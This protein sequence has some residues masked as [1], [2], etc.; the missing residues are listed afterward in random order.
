ML[1]ARNPAGLKITPA[2]LTEDLRAALD[3]PHPPI[4]VGAVHVLGNWLSGPDPAKALRADE[5]LRRIVANE[6]FV[7]ATAARAHLNPREVQESAGRQADDPAQREVHESA[8]RQADDPAQ[9]EALRYVPEHS[10]ETTPL[11]A[12]GASSVAARLLAAG[13]VILIIPICISALDILILLRNGALWPWWVI[14]AV[15]ILGIAVTL[16][17]I[18]QSTVSASI[19]LW[20]LAWFLIYSISIIAF[21]HSTYSGAADILLAECVIGA[22]GNVAL[23]A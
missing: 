21:I 2:P 7:V 18:R 12:H 22:I 19:V 13:S 16:G 4:R 11:T 9:R 23:C 14:V 8:G 5:V 15:S 20:N 10:A 3:S 6:V 1:L 17:G